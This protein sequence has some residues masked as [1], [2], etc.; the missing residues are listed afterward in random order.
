[1]IWKTLS[2]FFHVPAVRPVEPRPFD[3]SAREMF[4]PYQRVSSLTD[5]DV[6]TSLTQAGL[7]SGT[8]ADIAFVRRAIGDNPFAKGIDLRR[9][10]EPAPIEKLRELKVRANAV[11]TVDYLAILTAKGLAD[12][13]ETAQFLVSAYQSRLAGTNAIGRAAH[14]GIDH[15]E[16]IPNNMAAGPCAA[17]LKLSRHPIPAAD[18]P[19]GPLSECPHPDQCVLRWR[20]HLAFD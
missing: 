17:C 10:G 11:L 18:A 15:V 9:C 7:S 14:A 5:D 2:R 13:I 20:T 16:V 6:R 3:R 1:M 8:D 12:P 4:E 19:T